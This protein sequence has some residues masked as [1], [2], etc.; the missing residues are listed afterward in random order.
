MVQAVQ[1]RAQRR[2]SLDAMYEILDVLPF[3][4]NEAARYSDIVSAIGFSRS[5]IIDRMIAAQAIEAGAVLATLNA[6]DF[7]AIPRLM[8]ED[9]SSNSIHS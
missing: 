5:K 9:W 6:R 2:A 3:G 4:L 7:H 1:G 8:L